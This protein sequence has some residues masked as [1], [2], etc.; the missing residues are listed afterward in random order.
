M[1]AKPL[2]MAAQTDA[3]DDLIAELARLMADDARGNGGPAPD[4]P[5]AK[6]S[7]VRIPGG[8]PTPNAAPPRL[9]M[10]APGRSVPPVTPATGVRIPGGAPAAPAAPAAPE[11]FN[12]DFAV[13]LSNKPAGPTMP[14]AVAPVAA[15]PQT[16]VPVAPEQSE[17]PPALDQDSIASLIA[18]ELANDMTPDAEAAAP[19]A[20]D[21]AR[22]APKE[23]NFGVSPVFGLGTSAPAARPAM[24][25]AAAVTIVDPEPAPT[26]RQPVKAAPA[27]SGSVLRDIEDLVGPAVHMKSETVAAR[28]VQPAVVSAAPSAALRS[29][30][31]PTLPPIQSAPPPSARA[32][33]G[34]GSVDDA[35]LAAAAAT[36]A[37]VEWVDDDGMATTGDDMAPAGRLRR[38]RM[39]AIGI[40]R[41]VA[42]PVLAV[43][44]LAAAGF[45]IYWMLGQDVVPTGPAPLIAADATPIKEVPE[46]T[47]AEAPQS[48]VFNEMSGANDGTDEQLVSRDQA[49]EEAVTAATTAAAQAVPPADTTASGDTAL[50]DPNQDGL[51]NRKV[52]TVTVRPDGT[53]V[54]GE[55]SLAGASILPVDRPNVPEVPGAEAATT[56]TTA[57]TDPLAA[58]P[59]NPASVDPTASAVSPATATSDPAATTTPTTTALTTPL[60]GTDA[61]AAPDANAVIPG[62]TA[63]TEPTAVPVEPG[64]VVPVVDATGSAIAGRTVATPVQRP[65]NFSQAAT[66]AI[67][68]AAAATAPVSADEAT[69]QVPTGTSGSYVQLSSQR[70]EEA[71]RESAQAIATRYGVLFGGANLEIQRVDLAERGIYYRVLVPAPDRAGATNICTNV[72][73]AGGECFVL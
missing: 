50:V 70:T 10:S 34:A 27:A 64:A 12:F 11:K 21:A 33:T 46:P 25:S 32:T 3:P 35:I 51:V 2:S 15:P 22:A 18:A 68:N 72:Q 53:I 63:T 47:V 41:A 73:A 59:A 1:A 58:N 54:S 60:T 61:T 23:D 14:V 5:T 57:S 56:E 66:S 44:L 48:V 42:G 29:L 31:T 30:A 26:L 55:D 62:A 49:D 65:A 7:E 36:G 40:S 45:G 67:A 8:A 19:P 6:P 37:Q 9:D 69:A 39:P 38:P 4:A 71:A 17:S 20:A 24:Q 52:R 13:D 16:A 43:G 28:P